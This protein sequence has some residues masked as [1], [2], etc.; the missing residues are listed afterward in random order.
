M[1]RKREKKSLSPITLL[2]NDNSSMNLMV[3][4]KRIWQPK[5]WLRYIG[6]SLRLC[7]GINGGALE[8]PYMELSLS[9][10][11]GAKETNVEL[12]TTVIEQIR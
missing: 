5:R 4:G 7:H 8:I 1:L 2:L 6:K 9:R 3:C 11:L 12:W 10:M